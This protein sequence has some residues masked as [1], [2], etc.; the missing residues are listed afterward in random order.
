[1]SIP[2]ENP[3]SEEVARLYFRDVLLGLEYCKHLPYS[4]SSVK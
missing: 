1:M 3:L 4:V 2:T